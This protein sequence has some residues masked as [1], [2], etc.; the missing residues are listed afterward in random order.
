MMKTDNGTVND[1]SAGTE[2]RSA[3]SLRFSMTLSDPEVRTIPGNHHTTTMIV[4]A[5]PA[6]KQFADAV[7]RNLINTP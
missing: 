4:G 2:T 7:Q 6:T 3:N 5:N 1:A